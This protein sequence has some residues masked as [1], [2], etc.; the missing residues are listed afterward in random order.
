MDI[1]AIRAGANIIWANDIKQDAC[2]S[3][4]ANIGDHIQIGDIN[5]YMNDFSTISN[6]DL[7]IGGSPC[8]GFLLQEKWIEMMKEAN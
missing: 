1:G 4:R 6:V 2:D 8:Q 5:M 7:V 3:Y